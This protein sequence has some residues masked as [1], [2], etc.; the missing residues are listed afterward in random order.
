MPSPARWPAVTRAPLAGSSSRPLP[1]LERASTTQPSDK[2][3]ASKDKVYWWSGGPTRITGVALAPR[4]TR[5]IT[6]ARTSAPRRLSCTTSVTVFHPRRGDAA[7]TST[8]PKAA[9]NGDKPHPRQ[10]VHLRALSR[11]P[12][13]NRHHP[14]GFVPGAIPGLPARLGP[15]KI[16]PTLFWPDFRE[17]MFRCKNAS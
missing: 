4:V 10:S 15:F 13:E 6:S 2:G 3:P 5:R 9:R 17:K 11:K 8:G 7:S 16:S 1:R 12:P 14:G